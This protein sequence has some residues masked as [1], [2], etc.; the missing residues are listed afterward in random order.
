ML[1]SELLRFRDLQRVGIRNHPTLARWIR[2]QGFPSGRFIGP[3]TRVWTVEEVE[4]WWNSKLDPPPEITKP[5]PPVGAEG[6]GSESALAGNPSD[7]RSSRIDAMP[8]ASCKSG[9]A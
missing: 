6:T 8:Q 4:A 2:D 3:N 5:G 1:P 9:G 7:R